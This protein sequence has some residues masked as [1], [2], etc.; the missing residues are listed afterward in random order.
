MLVVF[1]K[2]VM[3]VWVD[4]FKV[5]LLIADFMGLVFL[6]ALLWI[7]IGACCISLLGQGEKKKKVS[8][9]RINIITA[10]KNVAT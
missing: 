1:I 10:T 6:L 2:I 5:L 8:S 3:A 4:T 9:T 7:C